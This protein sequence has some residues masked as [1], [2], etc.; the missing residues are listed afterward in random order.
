MEIY[1]IDGTLLKSVS[2]TK[3]AV[4]EQ[5]LMKS[6][7]IRLA[8]NDRTLYPLP[9]GS[10]IIVDGVRYMLLEDYTPKQNRH[11][12]FTYTPEFQHPL[13]WL[14]KIPFWHDIADPYDPSRTI[15]KYDWTYANYPQTIANYLANFVEELGI[16]DLN[17]HERPWTALV[18]SRLKVTGSCSFNSL[19]V[20]SAASVIANTF[21]CQFNF[22]FRAKQI[23]FGNFDEEFSL[24]FEEQGYTPV[25]LKSG[26]NVGVASV[27]ESKEDYHNAYLV[28]G[29]TRNLS[30]V[31]ES[32]DTVQVTERLTLNP[33]TN[34]DS[35]IYLSNDGEEISKAAFDASGVPLISK[36]LVFDDV[37]PKYNLYLYNI[38]ERRRWLLDPITNEK[39]RTTA[40]EGWGLNGEYYKYYSNW[41]FRLAYYTNEALSGKTPIR[42][43]TKGGKT[44]YWYDYDFENEAHGKVTSNTR[45]GNLDDSFVTDIP[46][47]SDLFS[48]EEKRMPPEAFP[49]YP[50]VPYY[51]V[52]VKKGNTTAVMAAFGYNGYIVLTN[53]FTSSSLLF[54]VN[55]TFSIVGGVNVSNFDDAH[56]KSPLIKD[57]VLSIS[58]QP[59]YDSEFTSPLTGREFELVHFSTETR[60]KEDDD[61]SQNGFTAQAGDFRIVFTEDGGL[62]LPTTYKGGM[63]PKPK[64]IETDGDVSY[65][66]PTLGNNIGTLFNIVIDD[67]WKQQAQQELKQAALTE[68][69]RLKKDLNKYSLPYNPVMYREHPIN[70]SIGQRAVYN[71]GQDLNGGEAYILPTQV[72]KLVT[73]L[74]KPEITTVTVGNEKTKGSI[75]TI[76]EQ[77]ET[78]IAGGT[79]S[80][81]GGMTESQFLNMLVNHGDKRYIRRD[82]NDETNTDLTLNNLIAKEGVKT[83]KIGGET[84]DVVEVEKD[85]QIDGDASVNGDASIEGDAQVDGDASIEG[86]AQVNGGLSVD[87]RF[88]ALYEAFINYLHSDNYDGDSPFGNGWMIKKS[89]ENHGNAS[90]MVIDNLFVRMKAIFTEL[91]IRKISYAGGNIILSHAG[92]T[93]TKVVP[94]Y[95]AQDV[96]AYRCYIK[97]DDGTTA[98]ENWWRVDDQARCQTFNISEGVHQNVGNQFYWR[99][100]VAV[101]SEVPSG[102]DTD[103]VYDYVD[104]SATDKIA[105]STIPAAGDMIVQ[106]G[107]RTDVSRQG[108]ITF[109]VYG[110][111]APAFKVYRNVSGFTLE[112]KR[113]LIISP[114]NTEITA[115]RIVQET[116]YDVS[117]VPMERGD[118][119]DIPDD[120]KCFYYDQVQHEGSTWLCIYPEEGI[121][122][123][124]YTT[125]EPGNSVYWKLYAKAGGNTATLY[126]Y[127]RSA[128]PISAIDWSATL[129]Y[130][131]S[132][133]S[134]NTVPSGWSLNTIPSGTDPI[135][136]TAATAYS[137]TAT[138]TIAPNEWATPVKYVEN[139]AQGAQGEHGINTATIFLYKR[140]A[141]A[142]GKPT[143]TLTYTFASGALSGD[144]AGW[145]KNIPASDGNPC[146]VIQATALGTGTTDTIAASEWS[147]QSKLVE[148]GR[149][150]RY[151]AEH[152]SIMYAVS[153]YGSPNSPSQ[154][155]PTDITSW[156]S[157]TPQPQKGKYLWTRD[158][159]A[160]DNGGV[161]ENTTSYGVSYW[162]TDGSSVNI[163]TSR[164]YVRYSSVKTAS[165]PA[166]STFTLV[167]PPALS[168]GDYLWVLSQTAYVGVAGAL[169]S[170]SVSRLGTDG[171]K[172]DPGPDGYTTHFAYATSSDGSEDFSTTNFVGATYI[173]TYR[174]NIA[175]D[176]TDYRDYVWTTW[177]GIDA[178][179]ATLVPNPNTIN[180]AWDDTN[181]AYI[182]SSL[183][184][185]CGFMITEG[186]L[187]TSYAGSVSD[188]T[189]L[190]NK[191]QYR[192]YARVHNSNGTFGN[193]VAWGISTVVI[194]V[195]NT[196]NSL[197]YEFVLSTA[198]DASAVADSNIVAHV[199]VPVVKGGKTGGD[200]LPAASL[201]TSLSQVNIPVDKD[202][203][204]L[205]DFRQTV[206]VRMYAGSSSLYLHDLWLGASSHKQINRL[207]LIAYPWSNASVN[208]ST[209]TLGTG[210]SVSGSTLTLDY[211]YQVVPFEFDVVATKGDTLTEE[212]LNIS[213]E[214]YDADRNLYFG[215]NVLNIARQ[216]IAEDGENGEDAVNV[217]L[218]SSVVLFTQDMDAGDD[219]AA[220]VLT[221]TP[222]TATARVNVLKGEVPQNA[223]VSISSTSHFNPSGV[224]IAGMDVTIN[225]AGIQVYEEDMKYYLYDNGYI[226]LSVAY[227]G[228][229]YTLRLSF[230][231]NV[232]GK[233]KTKVV[234]DTE[235]SVARKLTYGYDPETGTVKTLETFGQ[236]IRS[237]EQNISTISNTVNGHSTAIS[238]ISQKANSISLKVGNL[239]NLL[240]NAFFNYLLTDAYYNG[241]YSP[242]ANAVLY[243]DSLSR[244]GG[245]VLRITSAYIGS[246]TITS[247]FM[248]SSVKGAGIYLSAGTYTFQCV[249]RKYAGLDNAYVRVYYSQAQGAF[250]N[251]ITSLTVTNT[252]TYQT[253]QSTFTIEAAGYVA[254]RVEFSGVSSVA[255]YG[256]YLDA[257][258][259]E[260]GD[261]ASAMSDTNASA[262]GLEDVRQGIY[263]TG[264]DIENRKIVM[265]ADKFI[266]QNNSGVKTAWLDEM[267]NWITTGVQNNLITVITSS[268]AYNY[269]LLDSSGN[270][271]LDVLR[272]G[273]FILIQSLPSEMIGGRGS[274]IFIRLPYFING[275]ASQRCQTKFLT[276]V[277]HEMKSDEMRQLVGR[278][279][280]IRVATNVAAYTFLNGVANFNYYGTSVNALRRIINGQKVFNFNDAAWQ[281]YSLIPRVL[282]I[283]CQHAVLV[284]GNN[285]ETRHNAYVWTGQSD[286]LA[287]TDDG[288]DWT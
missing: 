76:K 173:G 46:C 159:T 27:T 135:Y 190:Y 89:D 57:K 193:W 4:H 15:R 238:Q 72:I 248:G 127:K 94:I 139:G 85:F 188:Y 124:K 272:C 196:N 182:P 165:R 206:T 132:T 265:T 149:S 251:Q 239:G 18:D 157:T 287:E 191:L 19:D 160:Y 219:T 258:K 218:D 181:D 54:S 252:A 263:A 113:V 264:I 163:D 167:N 209:L 115:R 240:Y 86:D 39:I 155:Y 90:Y 192:A 243:E 114:F 203:V 129:T 68:I 269:L 255:T 162:G 25:V 96:V 64:T 66:Y 74:D 29:S 103:E 126:L 77:I 67:S 168:Q 262:A 12:S 141:T 91:E 281:D 244:Y 109:E 216:Y 73:R 116:D 142:P 121:E 123:V 28:Q 146:W 210:A 97:K 48:G 79:S 62:R 148:D 95:G 176:S 7:F 105:G 260:M 119:D 41:Y 52:T 83:D 179:L 208:G 228:Q 235:T 23:R 204:V 13:M 63:Y 59:N 282:H 172:G 267:G 213:A 230:Y 227:N 174:D 247:D 106:M 226:D 110:S 187:N 152:S 32:G 161:I 26:E 104:L 266:C 84:G 242:Y 214:A 147:T 11:R 8:W 117:I 245:K 20:L 137:N 284:D 134:L 9:V 87:G 40:S 145:T 81:G 229:T 201:V 253:L 120:H 50:R 177:K 186:S 225:K 270:V 217:F 99:R 211:S 133:H 286:Y 151:D 170:Y 212:V 283:E 241:G 156:S 130:T 49:N 58:F 271:S 180:F 33:E 5:E 2:L 288:L 207:T 47:S 17:D 158:I 80:T 35:I 43:E 200:G 278:K 224:T 37:Y 107:N 169:K 261:V 44:Y 92:S 36:S 233:F 222:E 178:T 10:Y 171:G 205:E 254:F 280:T 93:I 166:D 112:G 24:T 144:L 102:E 232:M 276:G 21:D 71:N 275:G 136:V 78:I 285:N 215:R 131:F 98:T 164:T 231:V 273:D 250:S 34:P 70:L 221:V 1:S 38:R 53:D 101:G 69:A 88:K 60:E 189:T 183:A 195:S 3:D 246:Y 16:D 111:D 185:R 125:E 122:G 279:I 118:W 31:T 175:E 108:F 100:V 14:G 143:A 197:A 237:S 128:T 75:Q 198:T 274:E 55:D 61:I 199:V 202:G 223:V 194:N 150:V 249:A 153:S 256:V 154:D 65:T 184:L 6:N 257:V 268:N 140:G 30:K 42:T 56:K 22:D 234:G 45:L 220:H 82:I 259:L 236:Y 51:E 277:Q 138:D